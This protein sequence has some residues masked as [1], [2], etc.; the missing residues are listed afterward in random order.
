MK[1]NT[2]LM[3]WKFHAIPMR[4]KDKGYFFLKISA[5]ERIFNIIAH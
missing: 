2:T 3:G 5:R 1:R 4:R